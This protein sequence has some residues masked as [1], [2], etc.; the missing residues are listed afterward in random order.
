[1]SASVVSWPR[2][3]RMAPRA[4]VVGHAHGRQHVARLEG[5]AGARGSPRGTDAPFAQGQQELLALDAAPGTDGGGRAG[6]P[7]PGAPCGARRRPTR[8]ARRPTGRAARPTR[9]TASDRSAR[10]QAQRRRPAPP[11]R[12]RPGCRCAA[13]VLALRRADGGRCRSSGARPGRP[14]PTGPPTLCALSATRSAPDVA[15]GQVQEGGRLHGVGEDPGGAGRLPDRVGDPVQRLHHAGLVVGQHDRDQ[16]R[17]RVEQTRPARRRR[18]TRFRRRASSRQVTPGHRAAAR[19]DS[20]TAGCSTAEHTTTAERPSRTA[21]PS[22][23]K[24]ARLADSVPPEVK[25]IS[26]GSRP[27]WAATSSRASSSRRRARWAGRW[28][29]VGL[30]RGSDR[31]SAMACATSGRSGVVAP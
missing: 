30:P 3:N 13:R 7:P 27:S 28:L 1:M 26:P 16:C 21:A 19:H 9:R 18:P 15:V 29:P 5:A 25:M 11:P 8:A 20:R 2:V 10:G 14:T 17:L 23:P 31:A 6:R 24:T 22:A 12:P 4:S